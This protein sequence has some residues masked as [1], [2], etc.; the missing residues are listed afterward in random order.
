MLCFLLGLPQDDYVIIEGKIGII[1]TEC[2][3]S[4]KDNLKFVFSIVVHVENK[5]VPRSEKNIF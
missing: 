5:L 2:I 4:T 3:Y 1:V